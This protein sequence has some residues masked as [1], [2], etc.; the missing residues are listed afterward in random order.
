MLENT[1]IKTTANQVQSFMF[2]HQLLES[3]VQRSSDSIAVIQDDEQITYQ[4]LKQRSDQVAAFLQ[5]QGVGPEVVVGLYMKRSISMVIA[6][7]GI[8]KAGGVYFPID[9]SFPEARMRILLQDTQAAFL[10]TQASLSSNLYFYEGQLFIS[11]D[12]HT[13]PLQDSSYETRIT[14]DNLAYIIYTS[15]STG[16][17]KGTMISHKGLVN[18]ALTQARTFHVEAGARILQFA[19]LSFDASIA[20]ILL[21]LTTSTTL[22]LAPREALLL[23]S[24]LATYMEVKAITIATL[25]PSLLSMLDEARFSSPETIIVAG[26]A[27]TQE[28]IRRWGRQH[29][30]LNAYG[31]TE[32]TVCATIA[33]CHVEQDLVTI[34][35][36]IDNVE[37]YI[38]DESLRQ[39]RDGSIGEIYLGGIGIARGYLHQAALT[40]ECF[41]PH[42][43]SSQPGARLYKTGDRARFLPN[44]DIDYIGRS[45]RQVK[46]RGIRIELG[47]IESILT[48]F[49]GIRIAV[50]IASNHA[51]SMHKLIAYVIPEEGTHLTVT[52]IRQWL[53]H[54]LPEYMLPSNIVLI[55]S[56]PL[57]LQ[58]KVNRQAL[59]SLSQG[60]TYLP[61]DIIYA[62]TP[63]EKRIAMICE[64]ILSHPLIS[65]HTSLYEVGMHSL[66]AMQIIEKINQTFGIRLSVTQVFETPTI[67][68]LAHTVNAIHLAARGSSPLPPR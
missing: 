14:Q 25:P 9:T 65:I 16:K 7:L 48:R 11:E 6:F 19:S 68:S 18:L 27:C 58:G 34:G 17:P 59:L 67:A 56:L 45:D 24:D 23:N 63:T 35:Q 3:C 49:S 22:C 64:E 1:F 31:P 52:E 5:R 62:T 50:V 29:T 57:T 33:L 39:A 53:M 13:S 51:S 4:E 38:L 46:I 54:Q 8:L 26:E 66:S 44:G 60:S 41:V 37:V 12:L 32:N 28:I 40:A 2:L 21:A 43:F 55:S 61:Q 15:G 10:I 20:E 47:E 36:A 42:P 30:I